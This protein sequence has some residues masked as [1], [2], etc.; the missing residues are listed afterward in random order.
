MTFAAVMT[1][2]ASGDP[3]VAA[4]G[5]LAFGIGTVPALFVAGYGTR[6]LFRRSLYILQPM[7]RGVMAANS[8]V[9]LVM[10]GK[11]LA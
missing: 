4:F 10:A 6:F 3:A 5:M 9:L 11:L 1:V 8:I 7:A 2:A